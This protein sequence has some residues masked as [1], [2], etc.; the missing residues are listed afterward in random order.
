MHRR[1]I[2]SPR[3]G[4]CVRLWLSHV[5]LLNLHHRA[6]R[7]QAAEWRFVLKQSKEFTTTPQQMWRWKNMA[8]P[9]AAANHVLWPPGWCHNMVWFRLGPTWALVVADIQ[10]YYLAYAYIIHV[11]NGI[12]TWDHLCCRVTHIIDHIVN[13]KT[14]TVS[15]FR[16]L[17][18]L[19]QK[20]QPIWF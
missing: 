15:S 18:L 8:M 3:R 14:V 4:C 17:P 1:H 11:R 7:R 13:Q 5:E 6:R 9:P 2:S 20:T 10:Y 12:F 19:L 16:L